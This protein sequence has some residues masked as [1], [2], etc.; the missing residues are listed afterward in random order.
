MT[1]Y[2]LL[3]GINYKGTRNALNGC[4]NDVNTMRN[5]LVG[6][7]RYSR[8]NIT[9][10]TDDS[11]IKPT[12]KNIL[13][14]LKLLVRKSNS[15][16]E[17]WLHYSGHGSYTIDRNSD[18]SDRRDELIVPLD[19]SK[20]GN[21]LDDQLHAY[22]NGVSKKCRMYAIMDCC[23]SGTILDLKW[24]YEGNERSTVEN[25][26]SKI[27]SNILMISGCLDNQTS[28]DA[29]INKDWAGAMTTAFIKCEAYNTCQEL[30]VSMRKYLKSGRYT[31]KPIICSS[32]P[33]NKKDPI[34]IRAAKRQV[35]RKRRVRKNRTKS[36]KEVHRS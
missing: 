4:I 25:S 12:K 27:N 15:A 11:T 29:Y 10:L 31:Q 14:Q 34:F 22:I 18:E 13:E 6:K 36:I 20:E 17:I 3:I 1:S 35:R 23:H 24:R 9:T 2:A 32:Y 33:L 21:I 5:Y 30:L 19:H 7:R 28:A 8:R 16:D 26:K